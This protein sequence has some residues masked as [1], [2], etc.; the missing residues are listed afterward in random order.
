MKNKIIESIINIIFILSILLL[1]YSGTILL[2]SKISHGMKYKQAEMIYIDYE[3]KELNYTR[4]QVRS[5]IEN[6]VGKLPYFYKEKNI[7]STKRRYGETNLVLRIITMD[8]SIDTYTYIFN[9]AHEYLHLK[10]I[11]GSE[12]FVNFETFKLLYNSGNEDFKNIALKYAND[13]MRGYIDKDYQCWY[14]IKEY[15]KI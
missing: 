15:L 1:I 8:N 14:Y 11:T 13:D 2:Y 7:L 9:F 5:E 10:F 4:E 3:Y 6:M 12:R